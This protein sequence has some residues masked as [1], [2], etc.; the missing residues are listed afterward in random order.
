[1]E[2]IIL[3]AI[4][5]VPNLVIAVVIIWWFMQRFQQMLDDNKTTLERL[6]ALIENLI[7]RLDGE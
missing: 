2:Q 6:Y 4:E 5:Q 7:E 1:M 3:K